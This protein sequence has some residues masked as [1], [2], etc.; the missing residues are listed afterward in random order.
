M[1]KKTYASR[2]SWSILLLLIGLL[3]FSS[4][5]MI[6]NQAWLGLGILAFSAL[7]IASFYVRMAYT[8]TTDGKLDILCGLIYRNKIDIQSIKSIKPSASIL[9]APALSLSRLEIRYNERD[10]VLVSPA[11]EQEFV[12]ELKALNPKIETKGQI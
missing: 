1:P 8:I 3:G 4:A 6:L 11:R 10:F 7:F 12:A 9:S 5:V 2:I